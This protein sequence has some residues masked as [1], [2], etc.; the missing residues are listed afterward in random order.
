MGVVSKKT[1]KFQMETV[2]QKKKENPTNKFGGKER[3]GPAGNFPT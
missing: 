2:R 1:G 3:M